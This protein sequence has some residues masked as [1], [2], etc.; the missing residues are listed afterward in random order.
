MSSFPEVDTDRWANADKTTEAGG[1]GP[2]VDGVDME[3]YLK[4]NLKDEKLNTV[5]SINDVKWL[6]YGEQ[7]NE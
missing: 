5:A 7:D 1:L 6:L 3:D 2:R 4:Y